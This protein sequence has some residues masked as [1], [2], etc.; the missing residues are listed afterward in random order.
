MAG[1]IHDSVRYNENMSE[2]FAALL[3]NGL[4]NHARALIERVAE[5]ASRRG[6]PL[7]AVGGLPR[8][9]WLG[10]QPTDLDLV[11]EGDAIELGRALVARYGGRLTSHAKFGTAK[12]DLR[13]SQLLGSRPGDDLHPRDHP[14]RSLDLV[15][16]R[17]ESYRHP[18]ALPTVQGGTIRDDVRRRD[19][20]INTLA[21]RL[22]GPRFGEVMDDFGAIDDL[23]HRLIRVLHASSFIDDPTRMYRAVRYEQ[24]FAFTIADETLRL[25]PGAMGY[26]ERLSGQRIRHELDLILD[27]PE[28]STMLSRMAR[29]NLLQPIHPSLPHSRG[30]IDRV[31]KG[32]VDAPVGPFHCSRRDLSWMLWLLD[33]PQVEAASIVQRLRMTKAEALEITAAGELYRAADSLTHQRPSTATAFLDKYPAAAIY[34]VSLAVKDRQRR[35]LRAYLGA[36]NA[37]RPK[38]T[39]SDLKR[40][41]LR[42]GPEY[43]R[44]LDQ[45]RNAWLDGVITSADEEQHWLGKLLHEHAKKT[46]R[47]SGPRATTRKKTAAPKRGH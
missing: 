25:M 21:V 7:Y 37:M 16:A 29:L 45:L 18:A 27:E 36:W 13:G 26:V 33:L 35:A 14:G 11:V 47:G 39:G 28:A 19:F 31:K 30:A 24:R 17:N 8:D 12:W 23:Q 41:G 10:R 32:A 2:D 22:D 43:R 34:A 1:I 9:L 15:S 20:T 5:E 40:L 46:T 4:E 6:L 44:I 42:P 3:E 38:T